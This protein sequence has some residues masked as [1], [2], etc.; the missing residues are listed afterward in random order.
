M[1][2]AWLLIP[3]TGWADDDLDDRP[4]LRV[5]AEGKQNVSPDKAILAFGVETAGEHLADVQRDNQDR[6]KRILEAC[7]KLNI[8]PSRIQTTGLNVI[9]RYP[10]PPRRSAER[11]LEKHVPRI[12][13]YQVTHRVNVEV[14]DIE[15]VG[16]VV[17]RVLKA[18]A[19]RFSGISWGLQEEGPV[20]LEVLKAAS[21]KAQAKAQA[22]AQ[23]LQVKLVRVIQVNEGG[24]SVSPP[25][26][27]LRMAQ[28]AMAMMEGGGEASVSAGEITIRGTVT[29]VYEIQN[30]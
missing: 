26:R 13:G 25:I 18:G 10:P 6:M 16:K 24:V 9:P 8:P 28:P 23:A 12:I 3:H 22:L 14:R 19:N 20:K 29:L 1:I 27:S 5:S 30:P 2:G 11:A 7:R 4:Q 17:D 15:R 21:L